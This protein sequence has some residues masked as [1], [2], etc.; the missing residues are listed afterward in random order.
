MEFCP[1]PA[2]F[3]THEAPQLQQSPATSR[4]GQPAYDPAILLKLYLYGYQCGIRSSRKPEYQTFMNLELLWMC[5]G[6]RLSYKS[7]ADFRK[8]A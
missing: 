2:I 4:V 5:Q 8:D 3:R 6:A 7:I 1:P